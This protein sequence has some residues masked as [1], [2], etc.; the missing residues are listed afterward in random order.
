MEGAIT[1]GSLVAA[2]SAILGVVGGG[3][4]IWRMVAGQ[5][6]EVSKDLANQLARV[7][8]SLSDH[9]IYAAENFLRKDMRDEIFQALTRQ[10]EKLVEEIRAMR[11]DMDRHR[12]ATDE[13]ARSVAHL[14]GQFEGVRRPR[15]VRRT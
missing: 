5:I 4:K 3:I 10:E 9:K 11:L 12:A 14:V 6:N 1:W 15:T 13:L 7:E 2:I 8:K